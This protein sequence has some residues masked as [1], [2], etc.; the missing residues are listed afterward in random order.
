MPSPCANQDCAPPK[1]GEDP[2][3]C[4]F[5]NTG[6]CE[7]LTPTECANTVFGGV[8]GTTQGDGTSCATVNCSQPTIGSCC[9]DGVCSNSEYRD[10]VGAGGSWDWELCYDETDNPNGREC[11]APVL[12]ICCGKGQDPPCVENSSGTCPEGYTFV[13][14][15]TSCPE[16]DEE[17]CCTAHQDYGACCFCNFFNETVCIETTEE[18]CSGLPSSIFTPGKSCCQLED[19]QGGCKNNCKPPPGPDLTP[20]LYVRP[21]ILPVH[22]DLRDNQ[23]NS[24]VLL[25]RSAFDKTFA[26][27]N[28]FFRTGGVGQGSAIS[29]MSN[30]SVPGGNGISNIV[31]PPTQ[32]RH[33]IGIL[34]KP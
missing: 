1:T 22:F 13:N 23:K 5:G 8:T 29:G 11:E 17:Y 2:V 32:P 9:K 3:A 33:Q 18:V 30:P 28:V 34:R 12:G 19:E 24:R 27:N 7:D 6:Y 26:T 14:T 16:N 4:C 20:D 21:L 15:R 10:C 25:L 31:I